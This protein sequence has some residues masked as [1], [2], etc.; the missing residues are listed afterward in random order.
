M[1]AANAG[2]RVGQRAHLHAQD[3]QDAERHDDDG[4]EGFDQADAA[5]PWAVGCCHSMAGAVAAGEGGHTHGTSSITRI[6]PPEAM[7]M[8][9]V[10]GDEMPVEEG[11]KMKPLALR[12]LIIP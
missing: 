10:A 4:H 8:P 1:G 5:L 12:P 9:R 11:E 6:R 7:Q 3:A 2:L